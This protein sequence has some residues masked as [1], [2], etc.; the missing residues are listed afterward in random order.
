VQNGL[1]DIFIP[2]SEMTYN[3]VFFIRKGN[4]NDQQK[5]TYFG[6]QDQQI[7]ND[8]L[9]HDESDEQSDH[10]GKSGLDNSF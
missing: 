2:D 10:H 9:D 4:F 7:L 5:K 1:D 8:D 3:Q 6:T